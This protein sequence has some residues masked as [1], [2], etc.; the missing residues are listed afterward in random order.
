[1]RIGEF[2]AIPITPKNTIVISVLN[3]RSHFGRL[4]D[5]LESG[6]ESLVIEKRGRPRAVLLSI[7]EYVKLA[8]PEPS[9]LKIIGNESRGSGTSALS[10]HQIDGI[11][12]ASRLQKRKGR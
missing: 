3:V 8:A 11:I 7:K 10:R 1:M 12:R 6:G 4:L 9:V 2:M 5:R